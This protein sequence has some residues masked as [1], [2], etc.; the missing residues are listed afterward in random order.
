M[1]S[2]Q[3]CRADRERLALKVPTGDFN[4]FE[5]SMNL[6]NALF[7]TS[8]GKKVIMAVSGVV[9]IGFV[10][11]HLVD[12]LQIFDL[13]AQKKNI[14]FKKFFDIPLTFEEEIANRI[15]MERVFASQNVKQS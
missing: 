10:I 14:N 9:L 7:G 3:P 2:G 15:Q 1:S 13:K 11:G 4:P 8:I 5:Q 12:N 6:L